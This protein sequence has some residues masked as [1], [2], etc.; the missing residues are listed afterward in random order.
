MVR[1]HTRRVISPE[2]VNVDHTVQVPLW[3]KQW[4][5]A[6]EESTSSIV[7]KALVK[8]YELTPPPLGG[9][10]LDLPL[11]ESH[12]GALLIAEKVLM[13]VVNDP[14][15]DGLLRYECELLQRLLQRRRC[16][17]SKVLK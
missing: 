2:Q 9:V 12:L 3:V 10:S 8:H 17:V 15:E 6:Q 16:T 13:D 5:I 1:R 11:R 4:L 7:I 14:S